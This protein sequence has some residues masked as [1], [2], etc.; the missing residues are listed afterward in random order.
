[1]DATIWAIIVLCGTAAK[2]IGHSFVSAFKNAELRIL[3]GSMED[4]LFGAD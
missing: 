2:P 3:Y 4:A 1:M